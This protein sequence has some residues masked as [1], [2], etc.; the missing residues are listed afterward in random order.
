MAET[1][2]GPQNDTFRRLVERIDRRATFLGARRLTGGVSAEVI[3]VEMA[4]PGEDPVK[5][6]VRRHGETDR[7]HNPRI[8]RDEFALL[9]IVRAHGVA[10][11]EPVYLD[12][13]GELF[14][15]PVL[16]VAFIEGETAIAPAGLDEALARAAAELA[17]IHRVGDSPA[18]SFLPRQGSGFGE[19]PAVLDDAMGEGRIRDALESAWPLPQTN[20]SVLLHGDFWPGNLLWRDGALAGVIDWEDARIGDPLADFGNSRLEMLWAFGADAMETFTTRY[21]SSTAVDVANL[22]YW[23][24]C[25]AL[26]PCSKIAN[27]GLEAVTERRMRDQHAW[28]VGRGLA[29]LAS[30]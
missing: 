21:R 23:D 15:T 5:L 3:V 27:W 14:P 29:G 24:L 30:R 26:R 9:R 13:S 22:P 10:A 18:L 25:A 19:R 17:K 1:I 2:D 8:A 16:V 20:A 12:D 7:A 6:I 11:P 4:R 28:F